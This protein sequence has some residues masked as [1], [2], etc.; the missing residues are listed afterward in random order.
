ML[1]RMLIAAVM[2]STSALAAEQMIFI[3][4][5]VNSGNGEK[6]KAYIDVSTIRKEGAYQVV[7]LVS[8][9]DKPIDI[10]GYPGVKSMVNTFQV[11]CGRHVKRV[12]YIGFLNAT[13]RVI[14]EQQYPDAPD[15]QFGSDTID[16]SVTPYLCKSASV[17]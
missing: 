8:I 9:Y 14:V 7:K 15:E 17:P 12:T 11:N 3:G 16:R 13:G 2:C 6:Y 10:P 5:A 1:Y 4:D